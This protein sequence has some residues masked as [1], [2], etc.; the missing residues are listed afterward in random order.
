[1]S[2]IGMA[3]GLGPRAKAE[4]VRFTPFRQQ[5]SPHET[6]NKRHLRH[7]SG[8]KTWVC[9]TYMTGFDSLMPLK[10]GCGLGVGRRV[11]ITEVTGSIPVSLTK[12]FHTTML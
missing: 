10:S 2:P 9:K 4:G 6:L 3:L 7:E 8:G 11:R 12:S 5:S 1:M